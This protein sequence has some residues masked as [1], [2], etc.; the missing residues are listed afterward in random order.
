[1][2]GEGQQRRLTGK[3]ALVTGA[4]RGIGRQICIEL[5]AEGARLAAVGGRDLVGAEATAA[6]VEAVGGQALALQADIRDEGSVEKMVAATVKRFGGVDILVNNAGGG[7]IGKSL[8]ELSADEWDNAFA[9]NTRSAFLCSAAVARD[10]IARQA[11]GVIINI[12][13]ASAHR[14]YAGYGAYGPSKAAVISLTEQASIEWAP[15][16]IRVNGVS[17]G[18]IR[19]PDSNWQE[20]EPVLAEEVR[21]LPLRRAGT[22]KEVARTVAFLAGPDAGY[23]TG[24][25]IVVDGGGLNTWYLTGSLRQGRNKAYWGGE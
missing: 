16:G 25:V 1:M 17:P 23:I 12:A 10:M 24:Q 15:Y 21:R 20:R 22:R 11:G 9:L 8:H 13:G 2:H 5:A 4:S 7:G 14:N 6:E 19:D 18:P 3:V